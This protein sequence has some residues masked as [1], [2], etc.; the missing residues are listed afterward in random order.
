MTNKTA[1]AHLPNARHIDWVLADGKVRPQAWG[2][3]WAALTAFWNAD[4][5]AARGAAR[6][7]FWNTDRKADRNAAR[8]AV[9]SA[10]WDADLDASL[11]AAQHAAWDALT[12]LV[13]WDHAGDLFAM[14][15][16]QLRA[17]IKLSE[18]PAA[19]LLL[20]AVIAKESAGKSGDSAS[21]RHAQD[22]AAY[23]LTVSNLR[24]EIERLRNTLN[25]LAV[26][27]KMTVYELDDID[28]R[29]IPRVRKAIEYEDDGITMS[30]GIDHDD[31]CAALRLLLVIVDASMKEQK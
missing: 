24:A 9:W 27:N 25:M 17:H 15:A 7:A 18:D 12:A 26:K 3:A 13:A 11:D 14:T 19:V 22:I 1:W 31:I 30:G 28:L 5:G 2:D 6:T 10:F 23:E 4:W 21:E 16:Q 20:T 8:D 29:L